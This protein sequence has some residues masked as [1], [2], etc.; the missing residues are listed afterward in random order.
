M[1]MNFVMFFAEVG[2]S[3][4]QAPDRIAHLMST[5]RVVKLRRTPGY[6]IVVLMER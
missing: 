6:A 1:S 5:L 4:Y 2:A 3:D